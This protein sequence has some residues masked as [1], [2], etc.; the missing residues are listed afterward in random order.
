MQMLAFSCYLVLTPGNQ[1]RYVA[2][3]LAEAEAQARPGDRITFQSEIEVAEG[4][5][6]LK[7]LK[8]KLPK[9]PKDFP[10]KV[11]KPGA[12]AKDRATCGTCGRSWDDGIVTG[13][14]PAAAARCPFEQYH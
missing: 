3:S 10:V 7:L 11:L 14:T 2:D 12:K 8:R 6:V 4:E 9:V 5:L 13:L 1:V